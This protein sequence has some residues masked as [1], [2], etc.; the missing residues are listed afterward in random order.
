MQRGNDSKLRA[1]PLPTIF[2]SYELRDIYNADKFGLFYQQLPTK[3][4]HLKSERCARGKFSKVLLAGLAA[5]KYTHFSN[6]KGRKTTM[7]QRCQK[8][9]SSVQVPKEILDGL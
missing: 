4:F 3:S 1:D 8:P 6:W 5:R 9:T 2:S 7:F